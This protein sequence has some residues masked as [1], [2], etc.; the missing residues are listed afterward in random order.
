MHQ[1][2]TDIQEAQSNFSQ[3]IKRVLAGEEIIVREAGEP[4]VKILRYQK[5]NEPRIPGCWE[6]KIRIADD[7]DELPQGLIAVFNGEN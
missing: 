5:S 2:I 3:L 4:I 6:G 7:F 1:Y